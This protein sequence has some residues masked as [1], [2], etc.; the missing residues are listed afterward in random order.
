MP[1]TRYTVHLRLICF[2]PP[3]PTPT[4]SPPLF[5]L[6]ARDGTLLVGT[7]QADSLV[8]DV[9]VDALLEGNY[10]NFLGPYTH[11]TPLG[12]FLYLGYRPGDSTL[13]LRRLKIR[14]VGITKAQVEEALQTGG[15]IEGR[16]DGRG[17]GS[18]RLLDGWSVQ[19][20]AS[21]P[22]HEDSLR[23]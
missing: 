7:P 15:V 8:F 5:G 4:N 9:D 16:F 11:G 22:P 14:L 21:S 6:L 18:V 20:G 19:P 2:N 23:L 13:W 17:A 1:A 3:P 12:R 10:P